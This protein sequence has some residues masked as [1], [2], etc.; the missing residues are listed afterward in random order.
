M[1]PVDISTASFPPS[2]LICEA[3]IF[4]ATDTHA[5][6]IYI[7]YNYT[8]HYTKETPQ[9]VSCILLSMCKLQTISSNPCR[10]STST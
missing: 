5:L 1:E 3:A 7:T 10:M 4:P 6:H 8:Y 9:V 2:N